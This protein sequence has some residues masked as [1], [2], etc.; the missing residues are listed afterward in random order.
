MLMPFLKWAGGKRWLVES[1]QFPYP[2]CFRQY[3]EPFLGGGAVFFSLRPEAGVLADLNSRLIETYVAVRDHPIDVE[4]SLKERAKKHCDR[5][6]YSIRSVEY[7][8]VVERASQFI[9][10]NRTCF[11]GIYRE[12]LRGIFNVPRGSKNTVVFPTDDFTGWSQVLSGTKLLVSDFE[13]TIDMAGNGDFI[14]ADP[15]YTVKHN[16][17]GFVKYNQKIFSWD[18]QVRLAKAL[19]RAT[20]RGAIFLLTNANHP[21]VKELYSE[22]TDMRSISRH[23]VI[24]AAGKHRAATTEL[25]VSA[26]KQS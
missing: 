21:T 24:A 17:N 4:N 14:F 15:P 20:D 19:Q 25:L 26:L 3:F 11:N 13:R 7:S 1:G 16:K 18:D 12:N 5:Y 9:Y 23:S 10:L 6:Y 22:F 8:N 2:S